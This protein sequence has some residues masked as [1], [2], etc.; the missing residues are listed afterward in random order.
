MTPTE[1]AELRAMS[2]WILCTS[3]YVEARVGS[4]NHRGECCRALMNDARCNE[5]ADELLKKFA[6][7]FL[8]ANREG[9]E[10]PVTREWLRSLGSKAV[11]SDMGTDYYDH[12]EL[13][14][15]NF[16][17]FNDDHWLFS[18]ADRYPIRSR[19][20]FLK[21]LAGLEAKERG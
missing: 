18:E 19:G 1:L 15:L 8:A 4:D 9:E 5:R 7:A 13:H 17:E 11:P 3:F 20:Q 6:R 21:L 10:L 2:E 16:W 14:G 12:E